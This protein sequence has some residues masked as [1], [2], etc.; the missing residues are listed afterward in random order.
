MENTNTEI[1]FAV[2]NNVK[3][4]VATLERD[5]QRYDFNIEKI[6][7]TTFDENDRMDKKEVFYKF[8][9]DKDFMMTYN[10]KFEPIFNFS[11]I[12]NDLVEIIEKQLPCTEKRAISLNHLNNLLNGI[13][14]NPNV[15]THQTGLILQMMCTFDIKYNDYKVLIVHSFDESQSVTDP[16]KATSMYKKVALVNPVDESILIEIRFNDDGKVSDAYFSATNKD[17]LKEDIYNNEEI[18]LTMREAYRDIV[19][20]EKLYVPDNERFKK[21]REKHIA[22]LN[23]FESQNTDMSNSNV[24]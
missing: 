7:L 15:F 24:N 8:Y 2:E 9:L 20:L 6:D 11:V 10:E 21:L 5:N 12:P 13:R 1:Y 18:P 3:T 19:E 22:F 4:V 14:S 17:Y 23:S 16:E